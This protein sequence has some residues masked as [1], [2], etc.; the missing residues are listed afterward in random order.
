[1]AHPI[2]LELPPRD[3]RAELQTR[4]QNASLEHAEALLAAYQVLQGLHDQ[5]VLEVLQGALGSGDKLMNMATEALN[6]PVT[7]RGLSNIMI[8]ARVLGSIEPDLLEGFARSL[9]EAIAATKARQGTS[10]GFWG[11]LMKFRNQ[12]FRR[13][14]VLIN[15]LLEAFGKNL[16]RNDQ[17]A[18]TNQKSA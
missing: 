16:S 8:L 15:S 5:R 9:P 10:P 12:N 1:M 7:V 14:L 2:P 18:T 17:A 13:G 6:S 3:P 11:I 4:L